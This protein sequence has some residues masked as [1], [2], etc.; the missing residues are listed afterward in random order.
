MLYSIVPY[1]IRGVIWYQGEANARFG[2]EYRTVFPALIAHWRDLWGQPELP[3]LFAQLT[4]LEK[5]PLGLHWPL[6][7]ESQLVT[8]KTVPKTAMA[9][10]LDVGERN[11]IHPNNKKLVGDRLALAA[12]G[13]VY[14]QPGEIMGPLYKSSQIAEGKITI[15]FDHIGSGLMIKDGLSKGFEIA[16]EDRKFL[17]AEAKIDGETVIVSSPQVPSPLSVRYAWSDFPDYSIFNKVELLASPFR[18]D[19][20]SE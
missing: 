19:D 13:M 1:G 5:I 17:P 4:R 15:S 3:F 11:D 9:T 20:W 16:G 2:K 14:G 18:T 10:T 12:L 7:R 8:V 6:L